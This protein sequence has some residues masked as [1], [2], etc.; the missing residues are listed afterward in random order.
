M[1]AR[2]SSVLLV[3]A[4][5]ACGDGRVTSVLRDPNGPDGPTLSRQGALSV[6]LTGVCSIRAAEPA[7]VTPPFISETD[8]G[9]CEFPQLGRVAFYGKQVINFVAH[10]Q[11]AP[12]M[13]FTTSNGDELHAQNVGSNTSTGPTTI[14]FTGTTTITGGTGRFAN[15]TGR[16]G[17]EGSADLVTTKARMTFRGSIAYGAAERS[18]R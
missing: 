6:P 16:L 18:D 13:V 4:V 8:V 2:I 12:V 3:V 17:V 11:V 5:A 9:T 1:R 10:T 14:R 7:V 15:A